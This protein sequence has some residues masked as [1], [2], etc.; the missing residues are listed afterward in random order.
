MALKIYEDA[1]VDYSNVIQTKEYATGAAGI[2]VNKVTGENAITVVPGAAGKI[3]KQDIDNSSQTIKESSVFL[4]QLEAPI[5]AVEYAIEI[6]SINK[7]TTILNPAP[8]AKL[9]EKTLSLI[10]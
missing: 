7:V 4:T 1:G 5:E 3:T 6:A 2:L 9:N 8:A 10:D